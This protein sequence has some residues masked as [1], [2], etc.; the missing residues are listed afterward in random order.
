VP[1]ASRL[2]DK[3]Q[4]QLDA[5]GCPACPH[6]TIGPA[7][8]GSPNVLTNSRPAIRLN[9]PGIHAACCGTNTWKALRGSATVFIN[10]KAAV[11][12]G[13][14]TQHCGGI[15]KMVEGSP[16]VI[17]GDST[18]SGGGPVAASPTAMGQQ[19]SGGAG[20][21]AAASAGS[22][23]SPASS[24][25][26]AGGSLPQNAAPT[27]AQRDSNSQAQTRPE[28]DNFT[29]WIKPDAIRGGAMVGE[30]VQIVDPATKQI[31]AQTEVDKDGNVLASV[32]ENKPYDLNIVGDRD[33]IPG[34]GIENEDIASSTLHIGLFDYT[35]E[36]LEEGLK[37]TVTGN[38]AQHE[39]HTAADGSISP[40]L[41]E[42]VYELEINGQKFSAHTLRW[43][44]LAH[45]G[46]SPF[47]FQLAPDDSELDYNAIEQARQNRTRPSESDEV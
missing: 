10:N 45:E 38:G 9:D 27:S 13:D 33:V 1:E 43:I 4:N 24:P 7:I 22:S 34:E 41:P 47:Q 32:P 46:G 36:P 39:F 8:A 26:G 15:G 18:S 37:V 21:L 35:G 31:I 5:H 29:L 14:A 28:P 12:K 42:G 16:N 17:I 20:S 25:S 3:A 30:T 19:S 11:R 40:Q 6:P 2:G 23:S 44:D